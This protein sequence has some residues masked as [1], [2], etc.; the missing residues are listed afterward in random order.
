MLYLCSFNSF[1]HQDDKIL[2]GVSNATSGPTAQLGSKLNLGADKY[3]ERLNGEG[4]IHGQLIEMI[5]TDDGYEPY[6][7]KKNTD[8]LLKNFEI[9]ALFNYV[10]TPT[11]HAVF[12][13]VK[14]ENLLYFTPFTGAQFLRGDDAPS[15]INFRASYQDEVER[16]V[17]FLVVQKKIRQIGILVQAD[18]FG[19]TVEQEYIRALAKHNIKPKIITRYRR[20]TADIQWALTKLMRNGVEA[21]GVAGTYEPVAELISLAFQKQFTPYFVSVSF[22]S[23][24]DLFAAI[25]SQIGD[26]SVDLLVTEVV[27]EPSNCQ[28][29]LCQMFRKDF[30]DNKAIWHEPVIFEGYVNAHLFS[31]LAKRCKPKATKACVAEQI[32]K[33]KRIKSFLP[34]YPL[35]DEI[36]GEGVFLNHYLSLNQPK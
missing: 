26:S 12:N 23:S 11:S 6:L 20:N 35:L 21:V 5:K 2:L 34:D 16:H 25:N 3:F 30:S 10:G 29:T 33:I 15:I 28:A 13:K 1:S 31:Q 4:G 22:V 18:Q 7:T 36:S 9:F 14:K 8:I 32:N 19:S 24:R 17:D 27:P